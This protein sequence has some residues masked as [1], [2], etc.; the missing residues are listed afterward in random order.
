MKDKGEMLVLFYS[1]ITFFCKKIYLFDNLLT[2]MKYHVV[3]AFS[4]FCVK[5]ILLCQRPRL[6]KY[7]VG[8]GYIQGE[9]NKFEIINTT[10]WNLKGAPSIKTTLD[11]GFSRENEN[12][13]FHGKGSQTC[14]FQSCRNMVEINKSVCTMQW[15]KKSWHME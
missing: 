8:Q 15:K 3:I 10:I 9:I 13:K 12:C 4:L 6:Q 5:D 7:F 11:L 1:P 14:S 2:C